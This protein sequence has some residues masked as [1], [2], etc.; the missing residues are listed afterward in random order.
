MFMLNIEFLCLVKI[1]CYNILISFH[2]PIS[3][4]NG[5]STSFGYF[6]QVFSTFCLKMNFFKKRQKNENFKSC[7]FVNMYSELD[8]FLSTFRAH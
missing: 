4:C 5:I 1:G 6:S 7:F 8:E 3:T 2:F